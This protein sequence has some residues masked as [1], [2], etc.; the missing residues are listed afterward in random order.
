[1][2]VGVLRHLAPLQGVK[3]GMTTKDNPIED[4]NKWVGR[5]QGGDML[6]HP[7]GNFI[8]DHVAAFQY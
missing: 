4:C 6:G 3:A 7:Q 1:M 2:L 5:S 8:G